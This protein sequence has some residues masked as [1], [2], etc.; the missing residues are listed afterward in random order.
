MSNKKQPGEVSATKM[1]RLP[2]RRLSKK[3]ASQTVQS[4]KVTLFRAPKDRL[5]VYAIDEIKQQLQRAI[6]GA[7]E[8]IKALGF[9]D[10]EAERELDA[11][12]GEAQAGFG[13]D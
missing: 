7:R 3:L 12:L 11:M 1:K 10:Q 2:K 4:T 8:R 9:N 13:A 5:P 6:S